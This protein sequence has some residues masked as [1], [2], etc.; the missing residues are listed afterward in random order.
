MAET[1]NAKSVLIGRKKRDE[2]QKKEDADDRPCFISLFD[3]ND[4]HTKGLVPKKILEYVAHR[5]IIKDASKVSYLLAGNDILMNNL[6]EVRIDFLEHGH[7]IVRVR[8]QKK[9]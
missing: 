6:E 1:Y 7:V 9:D 3:E 2:K 5:V 8:Q 4:P